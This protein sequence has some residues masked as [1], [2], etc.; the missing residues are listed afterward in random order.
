MQLLANTTARQY[1][2][3]SIQLPVNTNAGQYNC[4]SIQLLVNT[5]ARQ[6]NCRPIQLPVNTTPR[7]KFWA[8]RGR[9]CL[10]EQFGQRK[11]HSRWTINQ[12][13]KWNCRMRNK[14][15]ALN[16]GERGRPNRSP[17]KL[18]VLPSKI[19][20]PS[21]HKWK[22]ELEPPLPEIKTAVLAI[23]LIERSKQPKWY[24]RPFLK[25]IRTVNRQ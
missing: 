6:Y 10:R 3:R 24:P 21:N 8:T 7:R 2:C 17:R 25:R 1:N 13:L 18:Q 20:L 4:S 16:G 19:G 11:S 23:I 5:I 9:K 14:G 22:V 12:K 15:I